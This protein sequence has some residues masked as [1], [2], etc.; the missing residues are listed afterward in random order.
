M[1]E[2]TDS[3][4]ARK[5]L[6][7]AE[8]LS[9]FDNEYEGLVRKHSLTTASTCQMSMKSGYADEVYDLVIVDEA[10]RAN[11]L[12][13]F[14]PM[15]MGK[16]IVLVGD[17]KQLPHMLEPDV[18]KLIKDD[19]KYKDLPGI[20]IS[21]FER[22]YNMFEKGS[23]PKSVLLTLQYRMHP[24]ICKFVSNEFYD[25]KLETAP[26]ITAE[27]RATPKELYFGKPL[28][29]VDIPRTCDT[30]GRGKSKFRYSEVRAI[31]D[32]VKKILKVVPDGKI[33]IIT[34]Y[35]KQAELLK[36]SMDDLLN[37]EQKSNIEVGTVD[38]FQGKEFDFVLLS[39]VRAN[40][41]EDL[42][43][44]VGFLIKPNRV[45]VAFSRAKRQIV[46]YG[47]S[48]TLNEIPYFKAYYNISK[49]DEGYYREY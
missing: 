20:E 41:K 15:S 2:L 8:F 32:D 29:Y 30:E 24:A 3:L 34:F 13:L 47:D 38:A 19:P 22:L 6:I 1:L 35:S 23:T 42:K 25:G 48:K 4:E 12:D 43:E 46:L 36:K 11:P 21:L 49:T 40:D 17:H 28:V 44:K 5:A 26:D 16:K 9:R 7:I 37:A 18:L 27:E 10:A 39:C 45:C 33:G 31:T 14:I